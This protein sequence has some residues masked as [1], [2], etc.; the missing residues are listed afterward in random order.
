[1][2]RVSFAAYNTSEDIEALV[3][4][5]QRITPRLQGAYKQSPESGE[6]SPVGYEDTMPAAFF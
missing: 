1:M 3:G 4:M 5:L 6:Y 2:V